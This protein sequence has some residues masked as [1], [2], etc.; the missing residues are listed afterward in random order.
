MCIYL[1]VFISTAVTAKAIYLPHIK[2][3]LQRKTYQ[4]ILWPNF[5]CNDFSCNISFIRNDQ[6]LA[7]W[8]CYN[9]YIRYFCIH[10]YTLYNNYKI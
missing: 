10:I 6:R 9:I 7:V 1:S 5:P 2:Y 4:A 3:A 8:Y